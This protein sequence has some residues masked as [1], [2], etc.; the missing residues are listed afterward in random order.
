MGSKLHNYNSWKIK[1]PPKIKH[2]LWQIASR[3]LRVTSDLGQC[4]VRCDTTC[5][6]CEAAEETINHALFECRPYFQQIL[7][8]SP[9]QIIPGSFPSNSV[10]LN[11][12]ILFW[13]LPVN[14]DERGKSHYF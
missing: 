13:R 2:F 14:A 11:L 5:Q 3:F 10:Y 9:I 1:A 4:E 6:R 8:L 7:E 12:Y